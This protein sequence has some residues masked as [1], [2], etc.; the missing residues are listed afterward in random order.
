MAVGP[1]VYPGTNSRKTTSLTVRQP[2]VE[3]VNS[4]DFDSVPIFPRYGFDPRLRTRFADDCANR[5]NFIPLVLSQSLGPGP[6]HSQAIGL[7]NFC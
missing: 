2:G 1:W 6:V 3:A 7:P 4:R 5:P